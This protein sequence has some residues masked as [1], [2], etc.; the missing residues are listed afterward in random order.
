ML[1]NT[2]I[3]SVLD[4]CLMVTNTPVQTGEQPREQTITAQIEPVVQ[5]PQ[6]DLAAKVEQVENPAVVFIPSKTAKKPRAKAKPKEP[7]VVAEVQPAE[8]KKKPGRPK[9]AVESVVVEMKG[10][11]DKPINADVGF[12]LELVHDR[13]AMFKKVFSQFKQFEVSEIEMNFDPQ[14]LKIFTKDHLQK[15]D[16]DT[17]VNGNFISRY[18][19]QRPIR[20][21]INRENM[22]KVLGALSRSI[23]KITFVLREEDYRKAMYVIT[24]DLLLG[25]ETTYVIDVKYKPEEHIGAVAANDDTNYPI[26]F[27]MP[28]KQFKSL[29]N[30]YRSMSPTLI[31][32]K[33]GE[34]PLEFT[35]EKAT[36]VNWSAACG[37]ADKIKLIST[38]PPDDIFSVS[39]F[40]DYFKPFADATIG[41]NVIIACD[42]HKRMSFMTQLDEKSEGWACCIK[43]Y[44]V[45]KEYREL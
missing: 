39:I 37:S 14:G 30:H 8:P 35:C 19:C 34:G 12:I 17:T 20:V 44:T 6:T 43:I 27:Q 24:Y 32:Q 25:F 9:K 21:C 38:L 40:I 22:A 1:S 3:N 42:K 33:N 7:K 16:I 11:V 36:G 15:S 41:D 26:K 2:E 29:I 13:P 31:I 23:Y 45:I 28:S 4:D 10:I 5:T 18:Y